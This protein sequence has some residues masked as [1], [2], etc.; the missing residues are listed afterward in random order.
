MPA[1]KAKK[2]KRLVIDASVARAAGP[3]HAEHPTAK[4][5][6]DFLITVLKVCHR[7]AMTDDIRGEWNEHQSSFTR[8][9][10]TQMT[11]RK[12]VVDLET[13]ERASLREKLL[14]TSRDDQARAAMGKDFLLLEAALHADFIV[15][16]LDEKVRNLFAAGARRV[17]EI[18]DIAWV[19]PDG[20]EAET[21]ESWLKDGAEPKRARTL[22]GATAK[23]ATP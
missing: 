23:D 11:S 16:S 14:A 9:W 20:D 5:C 15:I 2:S 4:R 13:D 7:V 3:E 22:G 17:G 1:K 10:R 19:N 6:R 18:R 8:T 12:K 21:V